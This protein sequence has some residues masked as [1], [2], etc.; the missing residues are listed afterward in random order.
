MSTN[1]LPFCPELAWRQSSPF[2]SERVMGV[3][4]GLVAR[5]IRDRSDHADRRIHL[6]AP[7]SASPASP[8]VTIVSGFSKTRYSPCANLCGEGSSHRR[9][10]GSPSSNT[11]RGSEIPGRE[12]GATPLQNCRS[13]SV[14]DDDHFVGGIR[15]VTANR[16]EERGKVL[17]VSC[18]SR[19]GSRPAGMS[20]QQRDRCVS[21]RSFQVFFEAKA[22]LFF[23]LDTASRSASAR[24]IWLENSSGPSA[25]YSNSDIRLQLRQRGPRLPVCPGHMYSYTLTGSTDLVSRFIRNGRVQTSNPRK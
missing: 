6:E 1:S 11:P 22:I 16:M 20:R 8:A 21:N 23:L 14:I 4:F 17:R 2:G 5:K 15:G 3:D 10:R 9:T 24:S 18:R 13:K 12:Y 25:K 7:R 19:R